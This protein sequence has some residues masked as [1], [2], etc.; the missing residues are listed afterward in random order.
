M[1]SSGL[2]SCPQCHNSGMS[3]YRYWES[4]T[5]Y[6]GEKQYIFYNVEK[7]TRGWKCWAIFSVWGCPIHAWWDPC[8]ICPNPCKFKKIN[9]DNYGDA[10]RIKKDN[11]VCCL[12]KIFIAFTLAYFFYLL[13]F[14]FLFIMI[15]IIA[16]AK[17]KI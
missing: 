4:R 9:H 15:F 11:F 10:D 8:N 5:I 1:S 16:F 2:L 7:Q 3:N 13:Y 12:T 17:K 14:T 6:N